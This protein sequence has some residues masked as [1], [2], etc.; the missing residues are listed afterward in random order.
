MEFEADRIATLLTWHPEDP[1]GR[2]ERHRNAAIY[3]LQGNHNPLIDRPQWAG[4]MEFALGL[5]T[6]PGG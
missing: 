3:E 1:P 4:R 6:R 2:W 5:L